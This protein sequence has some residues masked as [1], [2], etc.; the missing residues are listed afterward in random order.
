MT[1][2]RKRFYGDGASFAKGRWYASQRFHTGG[3]GLGALGDCWESRRVGSLPDG[4]PVSRYVV[5]VL[6]SEGREVDRLT[7]LA[8]TVTEAANHVRD[9]CRYN[10]PAQQVIAY[11]PKGGRVV[12]PISLRSMSGYIWRA[13]FDRWAHQ[14][15]ELLPY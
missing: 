1:R 13:V 6:A 7:V 11:G 2:R 8:S 10:Y 12:R 15:L 4:T 9:R 14:Q 5:R 3:A